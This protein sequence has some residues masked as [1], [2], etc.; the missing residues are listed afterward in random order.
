MI[1]FRKKI[2]KLE[3]R[4]RNGFI[5]PSLST[6]INIVYT[7][8]KDTPINANKDYNVVDLTII[9][10]DATDKWKN[11]LLSSLQYF[12]INGNLILYDNKLK[13]LPDT[14]CKVI[15]GGLFI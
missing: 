6:G 12:N 15:I 1:G 2:H 3:E 9:M 13:S 4:W 7:I 14:F 5:S 11:E 10:P 8:Y